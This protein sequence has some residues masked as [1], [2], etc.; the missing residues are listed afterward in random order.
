MDAYKPHIDYILA[1]GVAETAYILSHEGA[2]CGTNLPIQQL[3]S[4]EFDMEDENDPNK[5]HKIV[6]DERA[7]L[8]DAWKNKG[9]SHNPAGVRIYNQKYYTVRFAEDA[10][11]LKKVK[12][13]FNVRIKEEHVSLGLKTSLSSVHGI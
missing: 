3:P 4:Y 10:W 12:I 13:I 11:Y 6:V 9:V 8:I 1:G 5:T 7:N 2:L